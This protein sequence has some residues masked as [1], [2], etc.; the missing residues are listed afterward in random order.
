[1]VSLI[2]ATG[3]RIGEL[4]A[5]RW[6]CLDLQVARYGPGIGVRGSVPGTEDAAGTAHDSA[7]SSRRGGTQPASD[8]RDA[9]GRG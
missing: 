8:S 5:L 3:L 4:L 9:Q 7:R 1:M 6:S 2:A